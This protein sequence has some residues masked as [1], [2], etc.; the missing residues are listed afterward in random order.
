MLLRCMLS[1]IRR[2]VSFSLFVGLVAT[3]C[4][5]GDDAREEASHYAVD[6]IPCVQNSDCCVVNDGC[7]STAYVIAAKDSTT[8]TSLIA[9]A[10]NSPCDRCVTPM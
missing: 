3:A 2:F 7:H 10:D 9:S 1:D 8:V 6:P 4:G 5:G